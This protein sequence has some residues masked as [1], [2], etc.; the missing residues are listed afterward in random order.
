MK[1]YQIA[2]PV[3]ILAILT[4]LSGA[5]LL[6]QDL[7]ELY[8]S[9]FLVTEQDNENTSEVGQ[10]GSAH[11][12]AYF[13]VMV[14]GSERNFTQERF[15]LNSRYVHLENNRS[16]IVHKHATGVTWKMFF[17]TINLST[18]RENGEL[19]LNIYEETRC[20]KGSVILNGEF[21]ASLNQEISQDDNLLIILDTEEWRNVADEYM[22]KE[23]PEEY[24]P[25][26]WRGRSI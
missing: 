22:N 14:N 19:C 16:D 18:S 25:R 7:Q 9:E 21:N 11:G 23:L 5:L 15:Q 17:Q 4:G 26:S 3:L 24:R 13:H 12:H 1:R 8:N 10:P 6:D 2:A 20:G